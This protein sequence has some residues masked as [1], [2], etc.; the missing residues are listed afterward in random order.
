MSD[1]KSTQSTNRIIVFGSAI[2]RVDPDVASL[3]F[4]V[5]R[6]E[7]HPREAFQHVRE[8]VQQVRSFL[9]QMAIEEVGSSRISLNQSFR[10]V[11]GENRFLGYEAKVA[12]RVLLHDLDRTED[13]LTGI[14]DAGVNEISTV[15]FQTSRLKEMRA[16]VRRRAV[17]AA[18]EKASV[19]GAAAGVEIGS[20]LHIEDVNP[21]TLQGR[22]EAHSS[23]EPQV[24][25]DGPPRVFDPSSIVVGAA[26][27]IHFQLV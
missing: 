26:V 6:T 24:D 12:F 13:I 4:A 20:I 21:E 25:D 2:L 11:S 18:R 23:R 16:E 22:Y 3:A 8:A 14:V 9:V 27:R 7:Q 15:D 19:Y 5:T 1:I 17:A 10:F